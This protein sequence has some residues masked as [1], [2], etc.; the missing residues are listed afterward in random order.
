MAKDGRTYD[1]SFADIIAAGTR[2]VVLDDGTELELRPMPDEER[3]HALDPRVY[4]LT[5]KRLSGAFVTPAGVD[6]EAMR[7][8]PNKENHDIDD[9]NVTETVETMRLTGR[10]GDDLRDI[11]LYVFTPEGL[12][13]PA[14]VVAFYHGGGFT[15]GNIGMYRPALRYLAE[16]AGCVVVFPDYRLAPEHPFPAGLN[17]CDETLDYLVEH[18]ER[19]GIDMSRL[20]VAGDSAGGSLA[21]GVVQLRA[22]SG[23]VK[24]VMEM[25]PAVDSGPVPPEWSYDMYPWLPEQAV[26]AKSR[27]DRI[28]ASV[29]DLS[30]VYTAGDA[31]KMLDPLISAAYCEDL[32]VFPRTVVVSSEFD[33]LR[34]QNEKF[35]QQLRA[36]G[37]EVRAIRYLGCDHGFFEACGVMSQAE[38]LCRVMAAEVRK[39]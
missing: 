1:A 12:A 19:L 39:L 24:L 37:V 16:Q 35:A 25:Y 2:I 32:S 9:G 22:G 10:D 13:E 27:V 33:Y 38:D 14:P 11:E 6:F 23:L 3:E 7:K 31:Q 36:A 21:N 17:D 34:Y 15:V 29:D 26:E 28:K 30:A 20:A 8:R 5:Q 4:E 18:A